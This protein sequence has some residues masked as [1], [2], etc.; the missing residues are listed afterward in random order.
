M[1]KI[2]KLGYIVE[3]IISFKVG[4]NCYFTGTLHR[5]SDGSK[6]FTNYPVTIKRKNEWL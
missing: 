5:D 3:I 6:G 1:Y 2:K 4:Q